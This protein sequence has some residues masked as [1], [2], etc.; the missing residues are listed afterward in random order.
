MLVN[1]SHY[2]ITKKISSLIVFYDKLLSSKCRFKA[3]Y[4]TPKYIY[5]E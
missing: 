3:C 4:E 5:L 2:T 1:N